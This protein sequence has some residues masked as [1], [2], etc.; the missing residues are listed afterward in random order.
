M[1][2]TSESPTIPP[3][4][5][6][7]IDLEA[8]HES[9]ELVAGWRPERL[10]MTHFGADGDVDAELEQL[11]E[12]LDRWAALGREQRAR[13]S[14]WRRSV[15]KSQRAVSPEIAAAYEQAAPADQL[16][17]GIERYWRKRQRYPDRNVAGC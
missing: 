8:W 15:A 5:P 7:D 10:A 12:R 1:R 6:P 16:Y 9:I 2:I 17:A 13:R 3:T 14:S 11:S 4:P